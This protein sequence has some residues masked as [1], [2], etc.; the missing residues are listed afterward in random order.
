MH[1]GQKDEDGNCKE[2]K[3]EFNKLSDDCDCIC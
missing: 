3:V 2:E 1:I